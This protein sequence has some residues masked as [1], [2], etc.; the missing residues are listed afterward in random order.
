LRAE[1]ALQTWGH[2]PAPENPFFRPPIDGGDL[3][4]SEIR[5]LGNAV[6]VKID[7]RENRTRSGRIWIPESAR[8]NREYYTATVLSV[9]P[10]K[11]TKK[12]LIPNSVRPG[13]KI[14]FA[15]NGRELAKVAENVDIIRDSDIC[16]VVQ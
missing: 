16:A 9:G 12:A 11:R 1:R 10:G 8:D 3:D 2:D 14:I 13:Q 5:L 6:L 15:W 4:P 7:P